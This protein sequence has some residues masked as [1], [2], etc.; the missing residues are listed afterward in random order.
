MLAQVLTAALLLIGV[1]GVGLPLATGVGS[2]V[3]LP[4]ATEASLVPLG[5]I[6]ALGVFTLVIGH[7]GLL[8]A[9]LPWAWAGLGVAAAL[10][11]RT[12]TVRL[13]TATGRGIAT[14]F[15][16]HPTTVTV[17]TLALLV[18]VIA[19]LAAPNRID[20]VQYHWPAPMAWAQ[21]G[22]WNDSP[23]RHVDAFPFM[24]I[25]YTAAATQGSYVAAHLLSLATLV[26]LGFAAGGLASSMGLRG[27]AQVA[28]AAMCMPV[29]WDSSYAAYNDTPVGAYATAAV[30]VAVAGLD[31]KRLWAGVTV[32]AALIAVATSLKPT[33]IGAAGVVGLVLLL[34]MRGR[35]QTWRA[36][37]QQLVR[38]WLV[39][40][41]AAAT[42]L[43]FWSIRQLLITGHLIDPV[44][45][46]ES[47]ADTLSRLP[48][49]LDRIVAPLI[50]FVSGLIGSQ[51]PWGGR[52]SLVVQLFL[53][54]ALV[55]VVI[56]R[57]RVLQRFATLAVPAW[58]HWIILGLAIVRT[59]FHIISW[60]LLVSAV[61]VA[62]E[63]AQDRH[64]RWACWLERAWTLC[65]LLAVIDSGFEMIRTIRLL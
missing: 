52:T 24:E 25:V 13:A 44:L 61:R 6:A 58:A 31:S 26:G 35:E 46:G 28:A 9:W 64:P 19:A 16:T 55:Y 37:L 14:Q 22:H 53:I 65:I 32:S 33:A 51:E 29:V 47:S 4:T 39:L 12:S 50:P 40:G 2:R 41:G 63:D 49:T 38:P 1:A 27:V 36:S 59:R 20:E 17:V 23:Y 3:H 42:V 30:A 62:V 11:T 15:R 45:S 10:A 60:V 48:D 54:P 56:R 18:A 34:R 7:L 43:A 5:G 8:G 57:G 21:L